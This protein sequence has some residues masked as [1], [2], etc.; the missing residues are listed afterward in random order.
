MDSQTLIGYAVAAFIVLL[1]VVLRTRRT[2]RPIRRGGFGI[3]LPVLIFPIMIG[4]SIY[5][6]TQIPNH[7]FHLP[8]LWELLCAGLLGAG[9]GSLMLYHTGYEKREDGLIYSK[10]NKNF[11]YVLIAIIVLRFAL[12]QYFQGLDYTEFTV[13]TLVLAYLYIS[14]WRIGSYMKFRRVRL[15]LVE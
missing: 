6:L 14:V 2:K 3:L 7:P 11:K 8:V 13:L 15:G 12:A 1:V 4:F 10:P 9:L 5:S